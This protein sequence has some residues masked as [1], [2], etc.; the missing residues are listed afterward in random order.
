[1]S[2]I[3][4]ILEGRGADCINIVLRQPLTLEASHFWRERE[5]QR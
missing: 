5:P 4:G 3:R 2:G 1:M